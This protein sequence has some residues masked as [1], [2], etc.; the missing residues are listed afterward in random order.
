MRAVILSGFGGVDRFALQEIPEP[1]PGPGTVRIAVHAAGVN[2]V[3]AGNR[4]D[5]SWAGLAVPCVLGYDV[6]GVVD[7]VGPGVTEH[8]AGDRVMAMTGFPSGAGGYAESVIVPASEAAAIDDGTSFIEAAA[9]PLAAG[10]AAEVLDRLALPA[11][12]RLLVLGASGGVGLLL[13]QLAAHAGLDV[14]AVGRAATHSVMH[15]LGAR[16]CVDYTSSEFPQAVDEVDAVADLVGG[17]LVNQVVARIRPWGSIASIAT[18]LLDLDPV[19]DRNLTFHGVLIHN[20]GDR[21]RRL[22]AW[23]AEGVLRPVVSRVFPLEE[24]GAAHELVESGH[25]GGKVV[26]RVRG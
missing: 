10:T 25:A 2:P 7:A 8:A 22:A 23:L 13:V 16:T 1:E 17:E 20:H 18:P 15:G 3:D 24:V 11:G 19:L 14:T 6:A 4:A 5:G 12:N 9:T 26:L 21:T